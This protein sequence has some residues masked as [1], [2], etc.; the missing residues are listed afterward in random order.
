MKDFIKDKF[1]LRLQEK[2]Y[3]FK[4]NLN[5][6]HYYEAHYTCKTRQK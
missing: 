6:T 4:L 2:I 1:V 5:I 3:N